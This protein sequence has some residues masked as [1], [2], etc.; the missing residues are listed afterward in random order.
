MATNN[1]HKK[2]KVG[3]SLVIVG[4]GPNST[5]AMERLAA[6]LTAVPPNQPVHIHVVE[7]SGH[8]GAGWVHSPT[9]PPSSMLNRIVGQIAFACDETNVEAK[10]LLP[11]SQRPTFYEWCRD[12]FIKTQDKRFDLQPE[13]WPRRY[14]HGVAL[15]EMFAR[16]QDILETIPNVSVHLYNS[17]VVDVK[18]EQ[19]RYK[20]ALAD[21]EHGPITADHILFV[22]GHSV[23][24]P[25][26]GSHVELVQNFANQSG[27]PY[28]PF[29]YPLES[30][31]LA[32]FTS[33]E[34]VVGCVGLG[35]TAIDVILYLTEGRG[36]EFK[37]DANGRSYSY[38]ASGEEPAKIVGFS[39][40]G[41]F[42]G[43]RPFNAKEED[44]EKFEHRGVFFTEATIDQLREHLGI[45]TVG[46]DG[47]EI[48]QIDFEKHLFP[49]VYLEM[50]LLYYK[51]MF[52]EN[53]AVQLTELLT[54]AVQKF[55][56]TAMDAHQDMSAGID[57][58]VEQLNQSV[59]LVFDVI[60]QFI[61]GTPLAQIESQ[62]ATPFCKEVLTH[63]L[64]FI[65][66]FAQIERI[67]SVLDNDDRRDILAWFEHSTSPFGHEL[68]PKVHRFSWS[69]LISPI[70]PEQY[71]DGQSY[72][73]ALL[74]F[75]EYDHLQAEQGNLCNPS[76]AACDGVWRDLR[77]LFAYAADF[78]GFTASSH[79]VFVKQYMRYH[80][81]LANG[82]CIEVMEKMTAL[83]RAGILDVSLGPA[84]KIEPSNSD[85]KL[86]LNGC[87]G[88]QIKVDSLIDARLHD[89]D[90]RLDRTA[91]YSNLYQNGVIEAWEYPSHEEGVYYPGGI[92]LSGDFHPIDT[93][94]QINRALTFLGPVSEGVMFFQVGAA[95]PCQNHHVLSDIIEWSEELLSQIGTGSTQPQEELQHEVVS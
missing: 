55:M 15:V 67:S 35:L 66:G 18:P 36:G 9:Q 54:P 69:S 5:Y 89:L 21:A 16:Y 2:H 17:E 34:H 4:A 56:T 29:A 20:V 41:L 60:N 93:Q 85:T 1:N 3:F 68:A 30:N 52:G 59:D 79:E 33:K 42:T 39:Q 58:F 88:N 44:L 28:V 45:R 22:T 23:N 74:A 83:V 32:Q 57:Y 63:Y 76:K 94:G 43:A 92:K 19:E 84:P 80:N 86:L 13:D 64:Q 70:K 87:G 12:K 27:F 38:Q 31:V 71:C 7:K 11:K 26:E 73:K 8:F 49:I 48:V 14:L 77:Q 40:S 37:L 62:F 10:H 78:G 24:R 51:V 91:L 6:E 50:A 53:Y 47:Q 90:V 81:R 75:M 82:T 61:Q 46:E 25:R 65:F 72:T 95:R